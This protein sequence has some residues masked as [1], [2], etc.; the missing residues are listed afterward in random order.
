MFRR[1]GAEG[2]CSSK[3]GPAPDPF[4]SLRLVRRSILAPR[5]RPYVRAGRTTEIGPILGFAERRVDGAHMKPSSKI[6][7]LALI[8]ITAL[9]PSSGMAGPSGHSFAA[10][11]RGPQTVVPGTRAT[12][13]AR[14]AVNQQGRLPQ[15]RLRPGDSYGWPEYWP[16]TIADASAPGYAEQAQPQFYPAPYYPGLVYPQLGPGPHA[17]NK[18]LLIKIGA[19][20][21]RHDLPRVIYGTQPVCQG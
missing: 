12:H 11:P 21:P 5:A 3:A 17:C 8:A 14:A 10:P 18:S 6:V 2:R 13:P 19:Q 20:K 1:N 4:S 9:W 15:H 7:P 16:G